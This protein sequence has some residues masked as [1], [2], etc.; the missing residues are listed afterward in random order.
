MNQTN[1]TQRNR[2]TRHKYPQGLG[3]RFRGP[4]SQEVQRRVAF[5]LGG[6]IRTTLAWEA[7]WLRCES[8]A[9]VE[10]LTSANVNGA[11]RGRRDRH[12]RN[13]LFSTLPPVPRAQVT[14]SIA[15]PA[16]KGQCVPDS[17]VDTKSG[18]FLLSAQA[19]APR[20]FVHSLRWA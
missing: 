5:S 2:S 14:T 8:L 12:K 9:A 13:M 3:T 18:A 4:S 19:T 15:H 20:A 10:G 11:E 6:Q 1:K 16:G 7:G 17:T